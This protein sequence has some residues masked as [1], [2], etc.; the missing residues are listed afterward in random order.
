MAD[1]SCRRLVVTTTYIKATVENQLDPSLFMH[2]EIY[3]V[4]ELLTVGPT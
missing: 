2:V 1:R 3:R 4:S